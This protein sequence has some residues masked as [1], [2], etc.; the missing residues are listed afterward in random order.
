MNEK[1]EFLFNGVEKFW[2]KENAGFHI[3][4]KDGVLWYLVK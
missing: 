4:L 2:E 3:L 1:L